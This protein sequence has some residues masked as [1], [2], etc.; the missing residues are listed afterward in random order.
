MLQRK[1][2]FD[3]ASDT[4]GGFGMAD[5]RLHRTERGPSAFGLCGAEDFRE[6]AEFGGV[7]D[8]CAGAVRFDKF[9]GGWADAGVGVSAFHRLDLAFGAR[10]V[11]R[12]AAPVAGGADA[13]N[14]AVNPVAVALGVGEALEHDHADAFA[15]DGAVAVA[16]E[17]PRVPRWRERRGLAEAHEHEDVVE[18]VHAAADDHVTAACLQLQPRQ[19][20]RREAAR[21]GGVYHAVRSAQVEAAGDAARGDVAEQAGEGILLPRHVA[22]G[23]ALHDI[24]GDVIRHAGFLERAP[25]DGMAEPRAERDDEFER[26][27]DAQQH[28]RA[29]AVERF[30]VVARVGKGLLR[31]DHAEQL[32]RVRGLDVLGRDAEFQ[33]VE[34]HRRNEPAALR[35]G[36]VRGLRVGVE[37]VRAAPVRRRDGGDGVGAGLEVA[38]VSAQIIGL[39]EDGAETDNG[40]GRG[41]AHHLIWLCVQQLA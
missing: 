22:V 39:R 2:G 18:G 17:R 4:G 13:L 14:N 23:D 10:F 33:G 29:L 16:V 31:G 15:E 24:F 36:H 25:P 8:L 20:Q 37:E 3:E 35:V 6:R 9:H 1:R 26:A 12:A 5:L 28:A 32:R 11:N 7:A 41:L 38:P 40:E 27:S 34:I 19:M 21:A 30:L